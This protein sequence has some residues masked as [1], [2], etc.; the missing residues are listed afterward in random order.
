[1]AGTIA[2]RNNG[3]GVVGVAPNTKLYAVKVLNSSGNGTASQVICGIDWVTA[4][5]SSLGIKVVNMSL[6]GGG[7]PV[8]SCSTTTDAEHKAIC[9]STE[10]GVTYVVAAGNSG[11]DFDTRRHPTR[12]P[13]FQRC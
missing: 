12:R 6:G 8:Q 4:N 11:W 7:P 13:R 3:S 10:A 9:R 5:A 1:M 2:A